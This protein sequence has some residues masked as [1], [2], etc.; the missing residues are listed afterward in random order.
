[1]EGVEMNQDADRVLVNIDELLRGDLIVMPRF[2]ILK[3]VGIV[4]LLM[5]FAFLAGLVVGSTLPPVPLSFEQKQK[6]IHSY[7]Q[8]GGEVRWAWKRA[9]CDKPKV[10]PATKSESL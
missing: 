7:M 6:L 10:A 3:W 8:Q 5:L 9:Y 2:L 4:L 1:M